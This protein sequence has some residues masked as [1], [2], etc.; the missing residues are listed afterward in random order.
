M[1]CEHVKV[2]YYWLVEPDVKFTP[3]DL[4]EFFA[5]Y[6]DQKHEFLA[7]WFERMNPGWYQRARSLLSIDEEISQVVI[8]T[9]ADREVM[10]GILEHFGQP[11]I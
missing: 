4:Y 9:K 7:A 8:D 6:D 5:A 3:P 2:E 11:R 1:L 10:N